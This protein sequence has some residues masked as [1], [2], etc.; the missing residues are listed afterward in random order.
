MV[1][2]SPQQLRELQLR[3]LE[4]FTY[5]REFCEEQDLLIYFCGGCCIGALRNEGFIPWDDDI[6]L[7]M[8]RPDYE[9][10]A[11]LWP[12]HA[13]TERYSYVRSSQQMHT[14]TLMA[15]VVDNH[16]TCIME[17]QRDKDIPQGLSI[18]ILPLDAWPTS[19]FARRRQVLWAY[20]FSLFCAQAVPRNHGGLMA[21]GARILLGLIR[22]PHLRYRIWRMAEKHMAQTPFGS[23]DSVTELCS[24]PG[25]MRK[26]Y[27]T[28]CF[29][30]AVLYPF[31]GQLEPL[32]A[33]ADEYLRIAFGD[34][35][36]LPPPEKQKPHHA[37]AFLDLNTPYL[38]YRGIEYLQ[39]KQ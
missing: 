4:L 30:S 21:A 2:L 8:P 3:S 23:T 19:A 12:L 39:G 33:G 27:P 18:D 22:S 13:N 20:L 1:D 5:L 37:I 38:V 26:R 11:T 15:T 10:L 24:G 16:S 25:Y 17:G 7:F 35:L 9:R 32:P 36:K 14:G 28:D 31:E 6:D 34:Y 29:R